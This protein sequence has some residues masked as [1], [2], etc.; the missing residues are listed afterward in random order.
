[1]RLFR[2]VAVS[3]AFV[4]SPTVGAA[5]CEGF[6]DVDDSVGPTAPFCTDVAWIKNRDITLG[7]DTNLYC[8]FGDVN[9]LQIAAFLH[10][11]ANVTFQQGGN[12]FGSRGVLGT[13]DNQPLDVHVNNAR[14]MRY[15]PSP[16]SPNV[17][18]GSPFNSITA[19]VRGATIGG[20]GGPFGNDTGFALGPNQVTDAYGTVAGGYRN[21][22][23]DWTGDIVQAGGSTVGGGGNNVASGDHSTVAGGIG[24]SA[25]G[26][27]SV[28]A[29]GQGNVA[30]GNYSFVAGGFH[31]EANGLGAFAAGINARADLPGCFIFAGW[32]EVSGASCLGLPW[33]ARF[34]LNHGLSVDYHSRR[35]DGGGDRWVYI[36]DVFPDK[37]IA[38]WKGAFLSDAG[39][40]VDATSSSAA[41]TDFMSVDAREVLERVAAL[42]ITTW[43]YRTGEGEV[44]HIGPMAEDFHAAFDVGYGP[45]TIAD[46]DARGVAFAAIQGLNAKLEA[47]R[48]AK[49]A[50]IAALRAELAAI[51]SVLATI[52]GHRPMRTAVVAP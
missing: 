23:G 27:L 9:R 17:L 46:L 19:G 43:R 42:P 15:E 32:S 26:H 40:W 14:V 47:E 20:G 49:D 28:V 12:A 34:T 16:I 36:G 3:L 38:T 8:P 21:R 6:I 5:P 52:A 51:R 30:S 22:A 7:C 35:V 41:K 13:T 18:G 1:M 31:N 11:L 2:V 24:N 4:V 50:E 48:A 29:G 44:R 25:S 45:H 10:R 33:V 39:V 37:T